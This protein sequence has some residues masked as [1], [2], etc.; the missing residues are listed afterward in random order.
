MVHGFA[1][2]AALAGGVAQADE[3]VIVLPV[4]FQDSSEAFF[5]F[6]D[7]VFLEILITLF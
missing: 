3:R 2:G 7:A 4:P 5:G 6:L 1:E